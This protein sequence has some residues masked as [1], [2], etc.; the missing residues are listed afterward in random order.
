LTNISIPALVAK[1]VSNEKIY[2]DFTSISNN[3]LEKYVGDYWLE[4]DNVARKIYLRNDTLWYFRNKGNESPMQYIGKE[5]FIIMP[6]AKF[7]AKFI[8]NGEKVKTMVVESNVVKNCLYPFVPVNITTTYLS[9]FAGKYY[10][11]ELDVYYSFTLQNDTLIGY[12]QRHG[13]FKIEGQLKQDL[14]TSR[15]PLHTINFVRDKDKKIIGMRVSFDRVKNLWLEKTK[16]NGASTC[17]IKN[18]GLVG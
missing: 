16:I 6:K 8:F 4:G 3:N 5:E 13:T 7:K 18:W 12:N 9:E 10:C 14:F 17:N 1:P 15:G 11:P 2:S